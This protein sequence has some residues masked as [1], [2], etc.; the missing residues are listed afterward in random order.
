MAATPPCAM[1]FPGHAAHSAPSANRPTSPT[2]P[3]FFARSIGYAQCAMPAR[4]NVRCSLENAMHMEHG[5]K[6]YFSPR[7]P[8]FRPV[9]CRKACGTQCGSLRLDALAPFPALREMGRLSAR[10]RHGA[11]A[12]WSAVASLSSLPPPLGSGVASPVPKRSGLSAV[13]LAKVESTV[14]CQRVLPAPC[15]LGTHGLAPCVRVCTGTLCL[16]IGIAHCAP[17]AGGN[18]LPPRGI[19]LNFTVYMLHL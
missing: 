1:E 7:V 12:M 2:S 15:A 18:M 11:A 5:R 6:P 10:W 3:T 14:T 16:C 13:A 4:G 19:R 17:P 9:C 8:P